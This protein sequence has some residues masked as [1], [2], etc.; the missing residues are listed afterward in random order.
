MSW[1]RR[2]RR[3]EYLRGSLWFI[4]LI[5]AGL[6]P[7][8][9]L[10][11]VRLESG[12]TPPEQ[13]QYSAQT[14]STVLTAIV[15]AMVALTGFVVTL[16]V[17][18]VQMATGMLSPRFMRLWYR[19]ALQKAVLGVF[20][21]TLTF[22]FTLLGEVEDDSVPD[23]GVT[24]AGVLVSAGLVL[25]LLYLDRFIHRLRPVEIAALVGRAGTRGFLATVSPSP[26]GP[27]PEV[28]RAAP[29]RVVV[30]DGAGAI[31]AV[32]ARDLLAI[33]TRHQC[34]LLLRH[35]VGDFVTHGTPLV[36]VWGALPDAHRLCGMIAL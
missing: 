32:A 26:A 4:P 29:S 33:P 14:A 6:G 2:F 31:Q 7:P 13:L 19:D 5:S 25:F 3:R 11:C 35:P 10:L 22:A 16:G 36:D 27:L 15:G 9:A 8:L 23:L 1:A 28:A 17:L 30:S 21:G 34:A 24:V 18:I 12:L 20:L